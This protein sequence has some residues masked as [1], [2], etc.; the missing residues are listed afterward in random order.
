MDR[1]VEIDRKMGLQ[2]SVGEGRTAESYLHETVSRG[3][4]D[5]A[6]QKLAS[7]LKQKT[8]LEL[9]VMPL[10]NNIRGLYDRK[11][12]R[13]ILSNRIGA[14]EVM[15]QVVMHE[16]THYVENTSGYAAYED[17]ALNAA[18][19][20][21]EDALERDANELR[22]RYKEAGVAI[23]PDDVHRE[24]VAAATEKLLDAVGAWGKSGSEAIVYDL[25]GVKQS[26]P[27]RLYNKLT[28]FLAGRRAKKSGGEAVENY[29]ALVTARDN[30]KSAIREAGIWSEGK[31][32]Q[33][34]TVELDSAKRSRMQIET[35][36]EQTRMQ[37][38]IAPR[39]F[40]SKTVQRAD[41]ISD[42]VKQLLEG[43]TYETITTIK[44]INLSMI[45]VRAYAPS[46]AARWT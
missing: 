40:G 42:Q 10:A 20:G 6:T 36:S 39:A 4:L 21:N 12:G 45:K 26:F 7:Y 27:V 2:A 1:A 37:Y 31:G 15:R 23:D 44:A 24:L 13:L 35:D 9:I 14:G 29:R 16:L 11:S 33:D 19:R 46:A 41:A 18:Y 17:A 38:D 3:T 25:L 43:D 5:P 34:T 22:Q 28:Q 8:G 32:G 30:L